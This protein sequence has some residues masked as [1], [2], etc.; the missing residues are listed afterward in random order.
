MG[1]TD[2]KEE[3]IRSLAYA[4]MG[5][6]QLNKKVDDLRSD[7]KEHVEKSERSDYESC[8]IC[9]KRKTT[10]DALFNLLKE[11]NNK[12]RIN[13]IYMWGGVLFSIILSG[14]RFA[15]LAAEFI[16]KSIGAP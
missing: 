8:Q 12:F 3:T 7:L 6:N 15:V 10:C 14:G 11:N 16:I 5:I 9:T 2:S 1:E 13:M 4:K